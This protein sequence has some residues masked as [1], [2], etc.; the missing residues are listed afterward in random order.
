MYHTYLDCKIDDMKHVH[1]HISLNS[2]NTLEPRDEYR[3]LEQI[4]V[5]HFYRCNLSVCV[6]GSGVWCRA[7]RGKNRV[8]KGPSPRQKI[9]NVVVGQKK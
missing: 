1:V 4:M 7:I 3:R 2:V 6:V 5:Y 9:T 8:K